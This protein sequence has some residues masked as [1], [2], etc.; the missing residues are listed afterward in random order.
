MQAI[1]L[2]VPAITA[3][4][5]GPLF[6][7]AADSRFTLE[8]E[9]AATWQQKNDVQIPND[10]LGT[11]FSL[12]DLAGQGPWATGRINLN[13]D[14][15]NQHG[16]RVVLAP[17]AYDENGT[18]DRDIAF[19]GAQFSADTATSASYQFNSWRVGYRYRFYDQGAWDLWVGA[20]AKVRDAE[21]KLRQG[22]T[23][24]RDGNVGLVPLLY[25]AARYQINE[26]WYF[27]ADFDGLAGGPGRAIDLG[28]KLGYQLSDKW[29]V[30]LGYRTLE[31]GA[32]TDDVYN[33]AWF[34]SALAGVQYRF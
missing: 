11:R 32:D 14:I 34:H 33:F 5:L 30:Q 3:S 29:D 2:F 19:A 27:A 7:N 4:L 15:N 17:F 9:L 21:I 25:L 24:A 10:E 23:S 18:T 22:N 8:A 16:I 13:W 12:E 26:R 28:L 20:T 1:K 31:G 6:A